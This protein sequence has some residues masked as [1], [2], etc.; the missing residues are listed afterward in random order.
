MEKSIGQGISADLTVSFQCEKLWNCTISGERI[1]GKSNSVDI[2]ID[3]SFMKEQR[4]ICYTFGKGKTF[5]G[6]CRSEMQ[7]L[8]REHT[9]SFDADWKCRNGRCSFFERKSGISERCGISTDLYTGIKSRN[10][11]AASSGGIISTYTKYEENELEAL[12]NWADVVCIGCGLGK[13]IVP[14]QY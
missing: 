7:I 11:A 1:C 6:F 14:E 8:I 13:V 2:G 10:F 9:K 12:L 3:C 4:E 5:R